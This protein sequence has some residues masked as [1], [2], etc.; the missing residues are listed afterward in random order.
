[1]AP[2]FLTTNFG[3]TAVNPPLIARTR[4]VGFTK[5]VLAGGA[6]LHAAQTPRQRLRRLRMYAEALPIFTT[7]RSPQ[8]ALA[9]SKVGS[10]A[11][12]PVGLM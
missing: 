1:M 5:S 9:V 8:N 11:H 10:I 12:D 7:A 3:T 6:L 2:F 4:L